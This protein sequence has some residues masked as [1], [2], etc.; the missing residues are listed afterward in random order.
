MPRATGM[1]I[2]PVPTEGV[3]GPG[4]AATQSD[5]WDVADTL[6]VGA[7]G[8]GTLNVEDG[9]VVNKT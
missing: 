7:F 6:K 5:P 9:S 2:L 3:V 4:G 1:K 8:N